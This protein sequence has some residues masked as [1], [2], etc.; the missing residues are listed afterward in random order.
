MHILAQPVIER[1]RSILCSFTYFQVLLFWLLLYIIYQSKSN[2]YR[3][4][5]FWFSFY[6]SVKAFHLESS[7]WSLIQ[8][9]NNLFPT[10]WDK[11]FLSKQNSLSVLAYKLTKAKHMQTI[12][13]NGN[14]VQHTRKIYTM[15]GNLNGQLDYLG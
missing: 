9:F 8:E 10:T 14:V 12:L 6:K 7:Q 5:K 13:K 11:Y 15:Y 3:A 4:I 2:K 1:L